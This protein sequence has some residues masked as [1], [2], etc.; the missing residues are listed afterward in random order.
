V[1]LTQYLQAKGVIKLDIKFIDLEALSH[2]I[3]KIKDLLS[4]KVDKII[5][6]DLSTNDYTNEEKSKLS[7]IENSANNYVHPTYHAPSIIQQDIL[8]RFVTDGQISD[9]NAKATTNYVIDSVKTMASNVTG[10][11]PET[12]NSIEKVATAINNDPTYFATMSTT[13]KTK[14]DLD[15]GG[16]VL[17]SQLPS[18]VDDVLEGIYVS[19]TIFNNLSGNPYIPE[20]GKIYVDTIS[21]KTYS[22]VVFIL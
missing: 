15:S 2:A 18:Y 4:T 3:D 22:Q 5:G 21:N 19:T 10:L 17:S 13:L 12:L 14:A 8:N 11:A 16:K 1:I 20:T 7:G 6:K 9:W